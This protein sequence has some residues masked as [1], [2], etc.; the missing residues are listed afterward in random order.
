MA[1][2]ADRL[3]EKIRA[4]DSR[5]IVG[6]DPRIEQMPR[7]IS[8]T[9]ARSAIAEFHEMVLEA[10]ADLVPAVKPQLAF[11][12]QYGVAGIEAFES[13]VRAAKLRGL[14]VIADGKRNAQQIRDA[15][16]AEYGPVPLK[17]VVEYLEALEKIGVV[18]RTR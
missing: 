13:T 12:E 11:F 17:L 6:L 16:S 2:F 5:S 1:Q 14:L 10:V 8:R 18:A 7:F 15:V 9:S 4:K 3:L